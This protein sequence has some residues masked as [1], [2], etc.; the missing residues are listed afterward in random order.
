[1]DLII[2]IMRVALFRIGRL[3]Q[4]K[5]PLPQVRPIIEIIGSMCRAGAP[6]RRTPFGI[7][8]APLR[9]GKYLRVHDILALVFNKRTVFDKLPDKRQRRHCPLQTHQPIPRKPY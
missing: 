1:M 8:S 2:S 3:R 5:S 4:G 9:T 7:G 6:T